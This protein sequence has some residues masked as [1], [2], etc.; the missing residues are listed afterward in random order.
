MR[1][2]AGLTITVNDRSGGSVDLVSNASAHATSG[3]QRNLL[4]LKYFPLVPNLA[5]L[6]PSVRFRQCSYVGRK[7]SAK[8]SAVSGML[9]C[10]LQ[11]QGLFTALYTETYPGFSQRGLAICGRVSA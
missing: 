3:K 4:I 6:P 9:A 5:K 2:S 11:A 10:R 7:V 1:L 8:V